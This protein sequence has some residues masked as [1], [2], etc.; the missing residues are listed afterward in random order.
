[1]ASAEQLAAFPLF[2]GLTQAQQELVAGS[3]ARD[4]VFAAGATLMG[5]GD[6]AAGCWLIRLGQVAVGT[7]VPGRG[8][9]VVQTLGPGDVLGWSWLVPP[10]RWHYTATAK[11]E[12]SSIELDTGQLRSLA[13]A[14]PA[15]GF[16]LAL[17]FIEIVVARLQNTR[18]RLLDLYGSP[19]ER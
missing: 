9:V 14:D 5:E 18:S 19:R 10:H 4:V 15:L 11:T 6:A 2:S 16:P 13:E 8:L 17:G 1:M 7:Q 12:V 3:A